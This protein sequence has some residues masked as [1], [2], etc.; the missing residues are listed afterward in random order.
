MRVGI[1][2]PYTWD[3]PGGVQAHVRDLADHL[4]A[5]GH[6]V[7]VLTPVDDP[8][9]ADLPAYVVPAGDPPPTAEELVRHCA[10]RLARFKLPAGIELVTELP[11]SAIG[12]VRKGAL[13]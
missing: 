8:D 12:K 10:G 6:D 9:R 13:R 11:H 7:S 5:L 1:A 2:C 4:V 3:V